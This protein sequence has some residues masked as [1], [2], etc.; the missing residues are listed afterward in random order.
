[1]VCGTGIATSTAVAR[2]LE[3]ELKERGFTNVEIVESRVAE[4]ANLVKGG[5]YDLLLSTT[6]IPKEVEGVI[7]SLRALPLLTGIGKEELINEIVSILVKERKEE[8]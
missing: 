2:A 5:R 8:K 4:C 7:P 6:D 3:E 1:V